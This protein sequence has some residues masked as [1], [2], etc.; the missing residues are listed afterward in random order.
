MQNFYENLMLYDK[1][2]KA[3][4]EQ[5][6]SRFSFKKWFQIDVLLTTYS[7]VG[8]K[9]EDRKF[10]KRFK[11]NYVI[12]DEG[13]LLKNCSTERYKNLMKIHVIICFH[14]S[15]FIHYFHFL[16][17]YRFLIMK[18]FFRER[19]RY[20]LLERLYKIIWWN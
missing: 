2:K 11:I 8:S 4:L 14:Y 9:V 17:F 20:C 15:I 6:I 13:H 7:M 16:L 19:G 18:F 3:L 12:Y 1:L 5:I 10:F